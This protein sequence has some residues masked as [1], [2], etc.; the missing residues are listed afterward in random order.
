M[1]QPSV[2][3]LVRL[4]LLSERERDLRPVEIDF[5]RSLARDRENRRSRAFTECRIV[6]R[7]GPARSW[8]AFPAVTVCAIGS[9]GLP[10][11]SVQGLAFEFHA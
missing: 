9:L 11:C 6:R 8:R 5:G 10:V 7:I 2:S 3:A 4:V 1:R